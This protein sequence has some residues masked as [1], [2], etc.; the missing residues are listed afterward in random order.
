MTTLCAQIDKLRRILS[1]LG[2]RIHWP[3]DSKATSGLNNSDDDSAHLRPLVIQNLEL[4]TNLFSWTADRVI[5]RQSPNITTSSSLLT[6]KTL[7]ET[8]SLFIALCSYRNQLTNHLVRVSFASIALASSTHSLSS[9][10]EISSAFDVFEFLVVLFN[11]EY[12]FRT[13]NN[14]LIRSDFEATLNCLLHLNVIKKNSSK[15]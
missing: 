8:A 15:P 11:R 14:D 4:H 13:E 12:I 5:L 2:A 7:F 6:E 1:N 9:R 10:F 3:I